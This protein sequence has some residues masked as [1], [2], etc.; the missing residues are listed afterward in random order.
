MENSNRPPTPAERDAE[1]RAALVTSLAVLSARLPI[2]TGE[3]LATA[4]RR[5]VDVQAA[6]AAL[7]A[8]PTDD[9]VETAAVAAPENTAKPAPKRKAR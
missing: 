5:I 1:Q 3:R 9:V 2:D 4:K 8:E 7:P 6:L